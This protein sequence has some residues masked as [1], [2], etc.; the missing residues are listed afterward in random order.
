MLVQLAIDWFLK[1]GYVLVYLGR[2]KSFQVMS[3]LDSL[4]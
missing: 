3:E 4:L 2:N 1:S